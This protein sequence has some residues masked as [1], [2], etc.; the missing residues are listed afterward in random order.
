MR[1]VTKT[2]GREYIHE[3]VITVGSNLCISNRRLRRNGRDLH[4]DV[5]KFYQVP[6]ET[7]DSKAN[8]DCF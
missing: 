8:G 5:N 1:R 6:N 4:G 3:N 7:H 2:E